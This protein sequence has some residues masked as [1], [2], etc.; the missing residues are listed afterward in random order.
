MSE[1]GDELKHMVDE[2]EEAVATLTGLFKSLQDRVARLR[3]MLERQ[4]QGDDGPE[5][6]TPNP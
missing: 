5:E 6:P 3:E 2:A 1:L 4:S